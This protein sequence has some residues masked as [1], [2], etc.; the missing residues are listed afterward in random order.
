M[1]LEETEIKEKGKA[2]PGHIE[3]QGEEGC[4]LS[5]M[6]IGTIGEDAE[7]EHREGTSYKNCCEQFS[8]C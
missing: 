3:I 1:L 6:C 8:R 4:M 5:V 2:I 7:D